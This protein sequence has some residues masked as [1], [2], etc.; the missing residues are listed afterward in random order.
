MRFDW[1]LLDLVIVTL[2]KVLHIFSLLFL[3]VDLF[4]VWCE[5]YLICLFLKT[6][7]QI[8]EFF[9]RMKFN[10]LRYHCKR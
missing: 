7:D 6:L 1:I 9:L 8:Y 10:I 4:E 3:K 5:V 2:Y